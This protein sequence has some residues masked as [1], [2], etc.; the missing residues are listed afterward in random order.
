MNYKSS[1]LF[2]EY[3]DETVIK[4]IILFQSEILEERKKGLKDCK[5]VQNQQGKFHQLLR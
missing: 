3:N 2:P 4:T 1:Y 5:L